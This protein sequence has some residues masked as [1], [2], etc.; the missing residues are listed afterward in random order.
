MSQFG[1]DYKYQETPKQHLKLNSLKKLIN[2]EVGLKK[3]IGYKKE[4]YCK[5]S[6]EKFWKASVP[7]N[8]QYNIHNISIIWL[9]WET[10]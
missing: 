8:L 7:I 2:S 9:P 5:H 4:Y 6:D 10:I 1:D 3:H